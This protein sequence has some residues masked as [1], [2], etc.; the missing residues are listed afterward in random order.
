MES[1]ASAVGGRVLLGGGHTVAGRVWVFAMDADRNESGMSEGD[2]VVVGDRE[3]AQLKAIERGAAL[4]V[5]SNGADAGDA[6]RSQGG[7]RHAD[8]LAARQL[9]LR[10]YDHAG[11]A[12]QRADGP[13]AVHRRP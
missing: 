5:L 7:R 9:H 3:K 13:H 12:G 6:H 10:S 2:I 11:G 4:L 8:R 1:I